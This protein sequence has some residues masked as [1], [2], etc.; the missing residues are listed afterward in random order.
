[1]LS[2]IL[3]VIVIVLFALVLLFLFLVICLAASPKDRSEED[4]EQMNFLKRY[5]K[6]KDE[7]N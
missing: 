1:M 7:R 5:L 4:I 2:S 6:G 3:G